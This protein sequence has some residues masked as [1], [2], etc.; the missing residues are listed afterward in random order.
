MRLDIAELL[1][2]IVKERAEVLSDM[3]VSGDN[4]VDTIND[5]YIIKDM[6]ED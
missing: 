5:G 4:D 2:L 3:L 1:Y 6:L